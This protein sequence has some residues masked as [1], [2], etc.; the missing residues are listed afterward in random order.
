MRQDY[1]ITL[2]EKISYVYRQLCIFKAEID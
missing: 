1:A 2:N